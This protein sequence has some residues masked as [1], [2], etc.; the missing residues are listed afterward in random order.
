MAKKI[1]KGLTIEISGDTQKFSDSMKTINQEAKDIQSQLNLVNKMLKLD[2]NNTE[3]IREK[4]NLLSQS[5]QTTQEKIKSLKAAQ[6]ALD[7]EFESGKITET[8][9]KNATNDLNKEL[10]KTELQERLN[11]KEVD[12]AKK[13]VE[14]KTGVTQLATVANTAYAAS[15]NYVALAIAAV[16]AAASASIGVFAGVYASV[17][18][19]SKAVGDLAAKSAKAANILMICKKINMQLIK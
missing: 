9:Y 15:S 6:Q 19:L 14:Q 16:T 13:A 2:P 11:K 12:S 8:Q 17:L 4:F 3:L 7:K 18:G 10:H 5:L 1:L